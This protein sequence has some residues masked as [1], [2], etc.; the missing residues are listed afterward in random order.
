MNNKTTKKSLKLD[1]EEQGLLDSY[2]KGEWKSAKNI[3]KEKAT[4]KK[5]AHNTLLKGL[6]SRA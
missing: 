6:A 2:D 1:R 4:A 5:M 3:K